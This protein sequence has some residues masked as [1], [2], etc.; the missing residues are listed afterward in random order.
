LV[1][2]ETKNKLEK[3]INHYKDGYYQYSFIQ[4]NITRNQLS[5][6]F[7]PPSMTSLGYPPFFYGLSSYRPF[8]QEYRPLS[9][10]S[11]NSPYNED[12]VN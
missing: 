11:S 2:N 6:T 4:P 8:Y 7:Y 9:P 3:Q 12:E 5:Y 1:L 10:K